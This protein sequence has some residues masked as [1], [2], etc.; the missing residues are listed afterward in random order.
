MAERLRV[1]EYAPIPDAAGRLHDLRVGVA[2]LKLQLQPTFQQLR[3]DG[4]GVSLGNL[5][6]SFSLPN[7]DVVEVA[8]KV[9]TADWTTAVI[10]LLAD[11]TRLAVT[12]SQHSRPSNRKD[13]LTAALALE[14]AR[15]LERALRKDGP[16]T[17]YERRHEVS[18]KWRGRLDVTAWVRKSAI[19]PT[20]FPMGRDE[21]SASNDFTR[22]LSVVAGV[23]GRSA[24]GS[25]AASRLRRLQNM[26]IPGAP[27]PAFV[28][29]AVSHRRIPA[30]WKSYAPAWDIAAAI[31]RSRSVVGDPGRAAGVEVAVEPWKLLETLL[32][33]ALAVLASSRD[34]LYVEPKSKHTL[35]ETQ[36]DQ[37]EA[38]P[39]AFPRS[40][41]P[42]GLLKHA[43]GR[44]AAS[45]EAKYS[46]T[47]N[48]SHVYQA[49]ATAAA[50]DAPLAVLVYPWLEAPRRFNVQG[51]HGHP[52]V[53]VSIG[54]DLFSYRRGESDRKLA[55]ALGELLKQE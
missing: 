1:Q 18:R 37:D 33:R 52:R 25:E 20:M 47:P 32:E 19:D 11:D 34:D 8:P 36:P 51:F 41:E 5:V 14:Y 6:G 12:G 40:V 45:F 54:V 44:V 24:A 16:M 46:A 4:R 23:L 22:G 50:L 39:E 17:V 28:N 48:R 43:D 9:G 38:D 42:D 31:L 49:L 29:P 27:V 55:Y 2:E 10:H 21:L 35:L 13:D 3:I 30:Q 7:E 53:L 15:R 26:V